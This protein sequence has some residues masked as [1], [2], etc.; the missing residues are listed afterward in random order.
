MQDYLG[1][2]KHCLL[3]SSGV[4]ALGA[5]PARASLRLELSDVHA[6]E[7]SP[8]TVP[9]RGTFFDA[10]SDG[11]NWFVLF[12]DGTLI[13]RR[14]GPDGVPLGWPLSLT[15][16]SPNVGDAR[17][18]YDGTSYVV[19]WNDRLTY[20]WHAARVSTSGQMG[21]VLDFG[22]DI[23]TAAL[24]AGNGSSLVVLC[25]ASDCRTQ[26]ITSQG[27]LGAGQ[28]LEGVLGPV[29]LGF[30][31]DRYLAAFGDGKLTLAQVDA[32]GAFIDGTLTRWARTAKSAYQTSG[33]ARLGSFWLG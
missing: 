14:V 19:L 4:L 26:V 1:R 23:K 3:V 6:A 16:Y 18:V 5:A 24:A 7:L 27:A 29:A 2:A 22:D 32:D 31:R 9:E 8:R 15:T 21:T 30:S 10:A 12:T 17:V 11:Q 20:S 33:R 13:G 25:R 28:A